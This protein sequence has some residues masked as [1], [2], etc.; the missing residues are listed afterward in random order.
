ME[1]S[2]PANQQK[3]GTCPLPT[4]TQKAACLMLKW[5]FQRVSQSL[6]EMWG[7]N[8]DSIHT[9]CYI[10][11]VLTIISLPNQNWRWQV[12]T[13]TWFVRIQ[14][15]VGHRRNLVVST[16]ARPF[17]GEEQ[18]PKLWFDGLEMMLNSGLHKFWYAKQLQTVMS[19]LQGF[20]FFGPIT[21]STHTSLDQMS[22]ASYSLHILFVCQLF[23][24]SH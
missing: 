24:S 22:K 10:V 12:S 2:P 16:F 5:E 21:G 8:M 15:S 20:F 19:D 11:V 1:L 6:N 13:L 9:Y 23:D 14:S 4:R 3:R 7:V 18:L 17:L